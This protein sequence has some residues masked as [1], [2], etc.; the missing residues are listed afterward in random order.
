MDKL[1][2]GDKAALDGGTPAPNRGGASKVRF[3]GCANRVGRTIRPVTASA[4]TQGK[5]EPITGRGTGYTVPMLEAV[6][7]RPTWAPQ[8]DKE[9]KCTDIAGLCELSCP[10]GAVRL[11]NAELPEVVNG[12]RSIGGRS[13]GLFW[14]ATLQAVRLASHKRLL[15]TVEGTP[16]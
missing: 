12:K 1:G 13:D 14:Q 10:C 7:A 16:P 15:L 3:W 5:A 9:Q 6:A 4:N 2:P 11:T 8:R